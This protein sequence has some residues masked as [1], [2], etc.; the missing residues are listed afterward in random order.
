MSS[1]ALLQINIGQHSIA[2]QKPRNDDSY[3]AVIPED[4]TL[5]TKGI[6][7]AIADGMSS[8]AAPKEASE[9]CVRSFLEDYYATPESWTVKRS[10]ATVLKAINGWLYSQGQRRDF[11]DRGLV[12]TF[13]GIILRQGSAHIFHAGDSRISRLRGSTLEQLTNDHRLRLSGGLD[14]LSRAMGISQNL[15]IDYRFEPL[16]KGDIFI[17][18]TDGIHDF[19]TPREIAV[20]VTKAQ[21]DL[22]KA[23][24][25]LVKLAEKKGSTD[26]LTA[27]IFA[28]IE[29]GETDVAS[30]RAS[31][32]TLP[33][34]PAF[35]GGETLDGYCIIRPI[36]ESSRGQ[37]YLAKD[38]QTDEIVAI[39]TP[40]LNFEDDADYINGFAR[41]EWIGRLIASPNV[42]KIFTPK[43]QPKFLYHVTE[44]FDGKT[45]QQWMLDNPK[46]DLENVRSI[47]AQIVFGLRAMHR[48]NILHL[49][50]KPSNVMI[51]AQGLVKLIDFGSS[52]AASTAEDSQSS[53]RAGTA[54]Y[55]APEHLIGIKSSS[56]SDIFSLGVITYE[57]LT[58]F[59]PY[60]GGIKSAKQISKLQYLPTKTKRPD[61]PDWIDAALEQ[62]VQL[63]TQRRTEVLSAFVENL[64]K[65]NSAL[66]MARDRPLLER[67]PLLFWKGLSLVFFAASATLILLMGIKH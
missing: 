49:D 63:T 42:L 48:K 10:V 40:S 37:V 64:R 39:K 28:I 3:G 2:G 45:L 13:S 11:D 12:S 65:P 50:L 29:C 21:N 32:V 67:N 58:G 19:L 35:H 62:A 41:E 5:Q 52:L 59:L 22:N 15:E 56:L 14:H 55:A 8:C 38:T 27:Q 44:Y 25:Q 30:L 46:P 51:N 34:P 66:K 53:I 61:I 26:N 57:M 36:S 20:S 24:N 18:T 6:A 4:R 31:T 9:T 60:G 33:F 47:V 23:V 43:K 1:T 16:V 7:I 54:D 17:L